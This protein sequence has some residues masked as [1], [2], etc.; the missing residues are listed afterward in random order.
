MATPEECRAA[1]ESLTSRLG[2][3]APEHRAAHLVER[4]VSCEVPDLGITFMT[5]LGPE[6]A[7]P[8]T[9]MNGAG[10]QAQVRFTTRSDD[11]LAI[12]DDPGSFARAWLTGRIKVEASV[13]DL[14]RLR[15]LL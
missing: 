2:Q 7:A 14:L 15:K 11:L 6:G 1:L 9:E 3:L 4:D 12:A 10:N 13:F 8:V 5:R